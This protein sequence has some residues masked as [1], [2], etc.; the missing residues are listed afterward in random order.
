MR[1]VCSGAGPI[2]L[3]HEPVSGPQDPHS[4]VVTGLYFAR[5]ATPAGDGAAHF[6]LLSR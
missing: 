2:P 3:Y 1:V 6:V 5:V 4:P